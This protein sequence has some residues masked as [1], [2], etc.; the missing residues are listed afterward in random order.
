MRSFRS[1]TGGTDAA[2]LRI[3]LVNNMPD[4]AL[5]STETQFCELL[6]AAAGA[7]PL[8]LRLSSFP[9]L[10]RGA[11]GVEYVGGCWPLEELLAQPLDALI[12]TGTEPRAELLTAEPY[13]QRFAELLE[14]AERHTVASVWSC[15]AA[16]AIVEGLH[17]IRRRRLVEKRCGVY[18]HS[19]LAGDALLTGVTAPL[20]IPHSRW[21]E[22]P[23]DALREAG[24]RI[25]SWSA[26][27]GADAFA[28]RQRSLLLFF[29]GH[30]EYGATT[31]LKEYRRDV[32][33]YLAGQQASYPTLP[34][35][36]FSA[37]AH[38]ALE[39]FKKR[40][41]LERDPGLLMSF[42]YEPIA[43]TL[44]NPWRPAAVSIYRNWLSLVRAGRHSDFLTG[45]PAFV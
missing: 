3:G 12:V 42:P 39:A 6:A 14:Y 29:Q 15:L 21:N 43:A 32:G 27:T 4:A 1:A 24:Y 18:E 41:L 44:S 20:P 26:D 19:I 8:T 40:A 2:S 16:H 25:L 30:P 17:G 23:L 9:E 13:W 34:H 28:Y 5:R 11:E 22:L 45:S 7:Q 31:L 37:D 10:P 36:Y 33:R 38:S 35:G